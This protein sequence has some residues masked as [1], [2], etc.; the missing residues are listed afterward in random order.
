MHQPPAHGH[1]VTIVTD[2][3]VATRAQQLCSGVCI[4]RNH[5]SFV[6]LTNDVR[7][8]WLSLIGAVGGEKQERR[9]ARAF[10][11]LSLRLNNFSMRS[12]LVSCLFSPSPAYN[13]LSSAAPVNAA[14]VSLSSYLS[15]VPPP[16]RPGVRS[17]VIAVSSGEQLF[18]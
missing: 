16:S 14:H 11:P 1:G 2:H 9:Y 15:I 4:V 6:L 8:G 13:W 18:G 12:S 5:A 17:A 10:P 3:P 7:S